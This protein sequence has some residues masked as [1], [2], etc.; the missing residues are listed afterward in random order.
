MI[1]KNLGP[2]YFLKTSLDIVF[3]LLSQMASFL[4]TVFYF[5]ACAWCTLRNH[6]TS[7][8]ISMQAAGDDWSM[9]GAKSQG[10]EHYVIG[11]NFTLKALKR[12][13]KTLRM[14]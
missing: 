3:V 9:A 5:G 11:L 2:A 8:Q 14:I 12:Y 1:F 13:W 10:L 7:S 4:T 6:V